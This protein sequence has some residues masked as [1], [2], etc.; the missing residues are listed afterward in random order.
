VVA[1]MGNG[2]GDNQ[3][4]PDLTALL[5]DA[6]G[7]IP[8]T[9]SHANGNGPNARRT[10]HPVA[11]PSQPRAGG[12]RS[13]DYTVVA[14][15]RRQVSERLAKANVSPSDREQFGRHLVV[16]VVT[17]WATKYAA[18]HQALTE[19]EE[20][21]MIDAVY[22]A[23]FRHG[24]LQ[25]LLDHPDVE[26]IMIN[27]CDNVT[28]DFVDREQQRVGPVADSDAEL[29]ETINR[30]AALHGQGERALT[31]ASPMLHTRLGDGS[32]LAATIGITPRPYVVIRRHR[33]RDFDLD[34]LAATGM[35]DRTI[36]EFLRAALHAGKN[37]MITGTQGV[38]KTS[39]LRALAKEIPPDVRVGTLENEYELWLHDDPDRQVVP[40]EARE[41]NG[42]RGPD[43]REAGEIAIAEI[44]PTALRMILRRIIVGEVRSDE[45]VPMLQA[46]SAGDGGSLCTLHVRDARYTMERIVELCL[47]HGPSM[48]PA[49][50][51]RMATNAL[52]FIVHLRMVDKTRD[53]G[54]KYRFVE[55]VIEVTG[56]G[57]N[58][59]PSLQRI[60]QPV[61]REMRA[62]AVLRPS[63]I[64]ELEEAGFNPRLL[65]S[66]HQRWQDAGEGRR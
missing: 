43:G 24:R 60:F 29:V 40:F 15:L 51:Y 6:A 12:P 28:V 38:G 33:V 59:R 27:G 22:D 1:E 14:E 53:G 8:T 3:L 48:T 64:D 26:N 56:I 7:E 65:D 41:G 55:S 54:R 20:T 23:M 45:I 16:Q 2:H 57:E 13:M 19:A 50:A 61:P 11:V 25:P 63:C 9:V 39:L 18:G 52:D 49:L 34:A 5:R 17:E 62:A 4:H 66:A 35:L 47:K 31:P 42:E 36:A 44:F 58:E 46:M 10:T 37:L 30:L 21:A 32:R